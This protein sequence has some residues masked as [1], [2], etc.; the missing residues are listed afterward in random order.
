MR[1]DAPAH[2]DDRRQREQRV[3]DHGLRFPIIGVRSSTRGD[4]FGLGRK[5][6]TMAAMMIAMVIRHPR[7]PE[8][9]N[10]WRSRSQDNLP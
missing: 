1:R 3:S 5:N 10:L 8:E 2:R 9:R 6:T 4:G 7:T